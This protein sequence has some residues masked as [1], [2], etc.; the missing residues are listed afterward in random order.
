MAEDPDVFALGVSLVAK[1]T[2]RRVVERREK[3]NRP[4]SAFHV[5]DEFDGHKLRQQSAPIRIGGVRSLARW[6]AG[7]PR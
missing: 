6:D 4:R 7:R 5:L 2:G 1:V 3:T